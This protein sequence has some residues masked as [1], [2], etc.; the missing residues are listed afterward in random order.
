[1]LKTDTQNYQNAFKYTLEDN[2]KFHMGI[3]WYVYG[4]DQVIKITITMHPPI[5]HPMHHPMRRPMHGPACPS[6]TTPIPSQRYNTDWNYTIL[7]TIC[8]YLLKVLPLSWSLGYTP[9]RVLHHKIFVAHYFC[10]AYL[11][12]KFNT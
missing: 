2:L 10:H 6:T 5:H 7:L 4:T 12:L 9:L 3:L 11:Q 8:C 1:M